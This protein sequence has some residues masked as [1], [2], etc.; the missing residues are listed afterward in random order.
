MYKIWKSA[1]WLLLLSLA[2]PLFGANEN[3][4]S[5]G[6]SVLGMDFNAR[7]MAMGGSG[8][9]FAKSFDGISYNPAS[10]VK[11]ANPSAK[12]SVGNHFIGSAGGSLEYISFSDSLFSYGIELRY[13]NSG[14]ME[15]TELS[16]T[17]EYIDTGEYFGAQSAVIGAYFAHYFSDA[18]DGGAG[19]KFVYDS[20]D[21]HS[22]TA[23]ALDLGLLHHT[24]NE[25]IKVGLAVKNLGLQLSY[26]TKERYREELPTSYQAGIAMDISEKLLGSFEV[27]YA[28]GEDVK[29]KL[30]LEYLVHPLL[31]LR[32]GYRSNAKDYKMG[33]ALA[34]FS[35]LSF[36]L[37][38]QIGRVNLDYAIS[39]YGDLGIKN[40]ITVRYNFDR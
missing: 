16:P 19:L 3:A 14:E 11:V 8:L 12:A 10:L 4:G 26:Y 23:V 15:R 18:L 21:K 27:G 25:K 29:A 24:A 9:A 6:F 34:G 22:A 1:F 39:S 38:W 37:G 32:G 30:G 35:G 17:D 28:I 33:G 2:L 7:G 36:G 13:W 40:Q 31:V 5:T 20:I